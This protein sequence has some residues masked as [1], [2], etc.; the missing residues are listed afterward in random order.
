[1]RGK[2]IG[3]GINA[4]DIKPPGELSLQNGILVPKD[5]NFKPVKL[6]YKDEGRWGKVWL[7]DANGNMRAADNWMLKSE[8]RK[9]AK[10]M[11]LQ[12]EDF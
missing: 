8:A 6:G 9:I 11:K 12:F 2:D 10:K 1:M 3:L 5:S 7:E 4:S